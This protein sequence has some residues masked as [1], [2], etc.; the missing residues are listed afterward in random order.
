VT[1]DRLLLEIV[2]TA[3]KNKHL[4]VQPDKPRGFRDVS[5]KAAVTSARS[6]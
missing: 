5:I 2:E 6:A 1:V 4:L 3:S